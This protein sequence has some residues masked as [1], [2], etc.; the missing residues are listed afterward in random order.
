MKIKQQ[1]FHNMKDPI[2]T[3]LFLLVLASNLALG[4]VLNLS[5]KWLTFFLLVRSCTFDNI[6][7]AS[8]PSNYASSSCTGSGT[9]YTTATTMTHSKNS[10]SDSLKRIM[11]TYSTCKPKAVDIYG[12]NAVYE[13]MCYQWLLG[14]HWVYFFLQQPN[15]FISSPVG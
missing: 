14:Q 5:F 9:T 2:L 10:P 6:Y 7:P 11:I 1:I 12:N 4:I 3:S 13:P 15:Q 8:N